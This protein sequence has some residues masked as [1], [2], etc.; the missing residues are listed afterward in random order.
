MRLNLRNKL[1]LSFAAVLVLTVVVGWVGISQA[2]VIHRDA[3]AIAEDSLAGALA[4]SAIAQDTMLVR[5]NA[6]AHNL[7]D[8]TAKKAQIEQEIAA[9]DAR[10]DESIQAWRSSDLDG[11]EAAAIQALVQAWEFYKEGRDTLTL[12]ASRAGKTAEAA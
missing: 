4:I 2:D 6:L 9:I 1:L 10:V 7:S 8:D 5:A 12:A 11:S 3:K